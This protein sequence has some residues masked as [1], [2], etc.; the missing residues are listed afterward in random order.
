MG[1]LLA[2]IALVIVLGVVV[3]VH[4]LGHFLAARIFGARV[5]VFSIGFGPAILKW[6]DKRGTTWKLGILPL[7]GY[8]SVYGQEDMFDRKKYKSLPKAKKK[9]HYLSLSAWKQAIIIASGVLMNFILAWAIYSS[10]FALRARTVQL[11]VI[12]QV[13]QQSVAYN[14]GVRAGDVVARINGEKIGNWGD[15]IIAKELSAAHDADVVLIRGEGLVQVK[16][17]PAEKWGLIADGSKT[18]LQKKGFF[19]A[20][21]SGARETWVQSKTLVVVLK[22]IV[23]GE[24]SSKQLGSFITI[25]QISEKALSAGAWALLSIIALLSVNLGVINLL[26]LP[27]LDGGYLL[28]LAIEGIIR[29]KLQGRAM[30]WSLVIGW[31]IIIGIFILTMKND[32]FRL[33]GWN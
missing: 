22:Q 2:I 4:E 24:R 18:E 29:K 1:T 7:G 3:F 31:L 25:A 6:K 9:G 27:V 19:G 12:G 20:M 23:T 11:P 26:P 17:V 13:I 16:L 15:I 8:C 21:Y 10:M 33:L 30:E 28:I 14:A 5:D 32:I